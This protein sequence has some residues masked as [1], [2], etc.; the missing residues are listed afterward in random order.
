MCSESL[1]TYK[2]SLAFQ[3]CGRQT[4]AKFM[5]TTYEEKTRGRDD[6]KVTRRKTGLHEDTKDTKKTAGP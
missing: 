1:K 5:R 2:G 4:Q 3:S 6:A